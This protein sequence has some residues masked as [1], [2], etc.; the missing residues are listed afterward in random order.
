MPPVGLVFRDWVVH[1][2]K[3]C[4]AYMSS[5]HWFRLTLLHLMSMPVRIPY[6][7]ENTESARGKLYD[8]QS[9]TAASLRRVLVWIRVTYS[10][11]TGGQELEFMIVNPRG[12]MK[13][14]PQ[15][16]LGFTPTEVVRAS[17]S[18]DSQHVTAQSLS[19]FVSYF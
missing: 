10:V 1:V 17:N 9:V 5:T 7:D 13:S 15:N 14:N 12:G 16:F 11:F 8:R 6:P 2:T 3:Y 18:L 19:E 4:A